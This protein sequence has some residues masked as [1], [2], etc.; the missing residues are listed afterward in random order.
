[1]AEPKSKVAAQYF[2]LIVPPAFSPCADSRREFCQKFALRLPHTPTA[3]TRLSAKDRAVPMY[4]Q[5]SYPSFEV[6]G[7]IG[8]R[9]VSA[10]QLQGGKGTCVRYRTVSVV[11]SPLS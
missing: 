9:L 11:L 4:I 6:G 10:L 3:L 5:P 1:M 2:F 7:T 8:Y